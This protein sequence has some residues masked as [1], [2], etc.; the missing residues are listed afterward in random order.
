[1]DKLYH[2]KVERVARE[3]I[4]I[5]TGSEVENKVDLLHQRLGHLNKFQL[6]ELTNKDLVKG[7]NTQAAVHCLI[8]LHSPSG[9]H[10]TRGCRV[11]ISGNALLPVLQLTYACRVFNVEYNSPYPRLLAHC[12]H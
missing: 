6:R 12:T 10:S 2:L 5:V 11:Y 8:C 9:A 7:V 4:S 1:M 3:S